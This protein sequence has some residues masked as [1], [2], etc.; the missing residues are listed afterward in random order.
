[1]KI[2]PEEDPHW[3]D[4]HISLMAVTQVAKV[5]I[6]PSRVSATLYF[7][8]ISHLKLKKKI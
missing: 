6:N 8:P 7:W 3:H 5:G 1:M 2:K 4:L